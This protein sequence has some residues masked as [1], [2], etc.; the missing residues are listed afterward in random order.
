MCPWQYRNK[1]MGASLL[2]SGGPPSAPPLRVLPRVVGRSAS[3]PPVPMPLC[4][5]TPLPERPAGMYR[6]ERHSTISGGV[7]RHCALRTFQ[8]G[9]ARSRRTIPQLS[10]SPM[11]QCIQSESNAHLYSGTSWVPHNARLD[12]RRNTHHGVTRHCHPN[13]FIY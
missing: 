4:L 13:A 2:C 3:V 9:L 1:D 7:R 8:S 5:D 11:R 12:S 10:T 6:G